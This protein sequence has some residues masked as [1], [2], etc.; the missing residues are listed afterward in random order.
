MF[1]P[2]W[3]SSGVTIFGRG[4]CYLLLLLMWFMIRGICPTQPILR[5]YHPNNVRCTEKN[6][7][8][9]H[10]AILSILLLLRS[11]DSSVGIAAGYGL[12]S[13]GS[14]RGREKLLLSPLRP[15]RFWSPPRLLA[16]GQRGRFPR[17]GES[18]RGVKL[19][20]DM[21]L[22]PRSRMMELHLHSHMSSRHNV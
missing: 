6:Y 13:P 14:I 15:D 21:H 4:N 12:Q 11:R 8:T 16:N 7:E 19:T 10:Y 1:R 18:G 22:V 5:D 9:P 17:E 2:M 3:P 20:T